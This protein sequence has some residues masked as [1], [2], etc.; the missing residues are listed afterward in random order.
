MSEVLHI[1]TVEKNSREEVR[2]TLDEY[3]GHQLCDVRIYA[4]FQAGPVSMRGPTKKGVSFSTSKLPALI[5]ALEAA[6][7]EAERR[8]LLNAP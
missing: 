7:S 2:I 3:Q 8:G 1:A 6:R 4:D 5:E